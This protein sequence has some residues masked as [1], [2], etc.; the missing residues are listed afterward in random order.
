MTTHLEYFSAAH[1]AAQIERLRNIQEEVAANEAH[2]P[3]SGGSPYDAVPRPASLVLCGDFN[4]LPHEAEYAKLFMPPL[5]DAWK[6][7]RQN[8]AHPPTTGLHDRAQWPMGGHCRDYFAVPSDV[9]AR[10][11]AVE[12]D[13]ATD[14]SDHQPLRLALGD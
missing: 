3:K 9:A 7:A 10:I 5:L 13:E 2:P 8:E 6:V 11:K 4:L 14:A 1:R 12:M